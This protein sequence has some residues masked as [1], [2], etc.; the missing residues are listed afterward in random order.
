MARCTKC[1]G[2]YRSDGS[3]VD[4]P[5]YKG[6]VGHA[7]QDICFECYESYKYLIRS[8][9]WQAKFRA[10]DYQLQGYTQAETAEKMGIAPITVYRWKKELKSQIR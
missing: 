4:D 7:P 2:P 1:G 9:R 5:F 8:S 10:I 3:V 6:Q